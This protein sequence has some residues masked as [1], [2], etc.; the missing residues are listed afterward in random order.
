MAELSLK[1]RQKAIGAGS[2][3]LFAGIF[4]DEITC[5]DSTYAVKKISAR[6]SS[7]NRYGRRSSASWVLRCSVFET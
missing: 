4:L 3:A 5:A 1:G 2:A 7:V 6:F